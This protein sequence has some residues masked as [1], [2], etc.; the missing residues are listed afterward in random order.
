MLNICIWVNNKIWFK[1]LFNI[2]NAMFLQKNIKNKNNQQV[3]F[4]IP[5]NYIDLRFLA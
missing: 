1:R 3:N 4:I 5:K 2:G